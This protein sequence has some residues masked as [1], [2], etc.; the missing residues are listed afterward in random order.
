MCEEEHG[1][2]G[3]HH[4]EVVDAKVVKVLEGSG[5]GFDEGFRHRD[6]APVGKFLMN[7]H[8]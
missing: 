1:H 5:N 3:H 6:G 7:Y 8:V 4:D 2:H